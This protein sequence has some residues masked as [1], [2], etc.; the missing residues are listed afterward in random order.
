MRWLLAYTLLKNPSVAEQRKHNLK[1][2]ESAGG[3]EE[4]EGES[5][6]EFDG[7]A[8]AQDNPMLAESNLSSHVRQRDRA[9]AV[10]AGGRESPMVEM[11]PL[12]S[13]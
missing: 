11:S 12:Y 3:G 5:G 2:R 8:I 1:R 7:K 10:R 6:E 4:D 9:A 13:R